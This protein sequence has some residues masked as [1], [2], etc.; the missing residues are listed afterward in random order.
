MSRE[1]NIA[2][3]KQL[4]ADVATSNLNGVLN[5]LTDDI[6]WEPPFV[7]DIHHTRLRYGKNEVKDCI[8]E[9]AAEI[10]YAQV[11]PQ[12]LYADNDAVIVKG[13]FEGRANNTGKPFASDWVHIWRFRDDRIC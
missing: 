12:T 1:Q 8:S 13:F 2:T 10:T 3:V 5:I 6:R 11:T 7:P 9:M 4:Y